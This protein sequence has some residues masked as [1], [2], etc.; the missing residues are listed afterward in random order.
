[1]LCLCSH[2]RL[3]QIGEQ[4]NHGGSLESIN[5]VLGCPV[6]MFAMDDELKK[7][8]ASTFSIVQRNLV[9]SAIFFGINWLREVINAFAEQPDKDLQ[10]KTLERLHQLVELERFLDE[11]LQN[12]PRF[13]L[14]GSA[15]T[16]ASAALTMPKPVAAA[17]GKGKGKAV[18]I[19]P[20]SSSSG[21]GG[22]GDPPPSTT[23][24]MATNTGNDALASSNGKTLTVQ[25]LRPLM[26]ELEMSAFATLKYEKLFRYDPAYSQNSASSANISSQQA[27]LTIRHPI[28]LES[29]HLQ[30]LLGD[31]AVKLASKLP[32]ASSSSR[33]PWAKA[34]QPVEQSPRLSRLR[35]DEFASRVVGILPSLC[36][37]L[38][39]IATR[40]QALMDDDGMLDESDALVVKSDSCIQLI[41]RTFERLLQWTELS[42][43]EHQPLLK[44]IVQHFAKRLQPTNGDA[45]ETTIAQQASNA[46]AYLLGLSQALQTVKS[47]MSLHALL[48]TFLQL[49]L[50]SWPDARSEF[51]QLG[52]QLSDFAGRLLQKKN[53][54]KET[55]KADAVNVLLAS[56][57]TRHANALETITEFVKVLL[58]ALAREDDSNEA[59]TAILAKYPSLRRDTVGTY[60]KVI[61]HELGPTMAHE[62]VREIEG[63]WTSDLM[64]LSCKYC[65]SQ[66]SRPRLRSRSL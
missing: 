29:D 10:S 54:T 58:P 15:S 40:L 12:H 11:L 50:T 57:I 24:T 39:T 52:H 46:F 41:L 5:A 49:L 56:F 59:D 53:V 2:F 19:D 44:T 51:E 32:T 21:G 14:V 63:S 42:S 65:R 3:F 66:V 31:L 36:V 37:H 8:F 25:L 34:A 43:T 61:L 6:G 28:A 62:L 33:L 45:Q 4:I 30:Y 23:A 20:P 1:M 18:D 17:K 64:C 13:T 38:E 55:M 26:Q 22:G 9:C 35:V 27:L 7:A 48:S 47:L 16:S 60:F